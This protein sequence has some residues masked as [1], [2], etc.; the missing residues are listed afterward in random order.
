MMNFAEY[1]RGF[2]ESGMWS[3]SRHPNYFCEVALWW[4]FYLFSVAATDT[5]N[6]G[7]E[8]WVNWTFLG[9]FF[10]S[11]LFVPPGASLDVT[12][13]LSSRKYVHYTEYQANVS[14]FIP[15]PPRTVGDPLAVRLAEAT[16][17]PA[18]D[19]TKSGQ[20]LVQK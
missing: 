10:L 4:A 15:L 18:V 20:F 3:W 11:C 2:I 17:A 8:R 5:A 9:P 16:P 7:W 6:E 1:E 19:E 13:S 14:R 12:E